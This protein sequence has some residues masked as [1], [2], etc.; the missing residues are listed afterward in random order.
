MERV[1]VW[2]VSQTCSK[3]NRMPIQFRGPWPKMKKA[4]GLRLAFDSWLKLSGSKTS[5]FGKYS[6]SFMIID[7][8]KVLEQS[9]MG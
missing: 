6:D 7:L 8:G 3:P 5:G 9:I 4:Y 2:R 1:R